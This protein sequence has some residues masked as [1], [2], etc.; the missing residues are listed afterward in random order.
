VVQPSVF[1]GRELCKGRMVRVMRARDGR[2]K[3]L[4]CVESYDDGLLKMLYAT[5]ESASLKLPNAK[6]CVV[7]G[8]HASCNNL[9]S[10]LVERVGSFLSAR[11]ARRLSVVSRSWRCVG[12]DSLWR[13]RLVR[14]WP[15][16]TPEAAPESCCLA[17]YRSRLVAERSLRQAQ[18]FS[19]RKGGFLPRLCGWPSCTAA[20]T[21]RRAAL[22]H[23]VDH[24]RCWAPKSDEDAAWLKAERFRIDRRDQQLANRAEVR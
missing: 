5:G 16:P 3:S 21:D 4:A 2:N 14:R 1:C 11:R 17:L 20:L 15:P 23:S 6:W 7:F 19:N 10:D 24:A 12:S 8:H 18:R 13:S 9:P 22:K